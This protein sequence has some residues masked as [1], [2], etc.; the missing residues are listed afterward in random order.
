MEHETT[1]SIKALSH[2]HLVSTK[3]LDQEI[4]GSC[5]QFG[6]FGRFF[7]CLLC[8]VRGNWWCIINLDA[9]SLLV[10]AVVEG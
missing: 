10:F 2:V 1:W 9:A 5:T 4:Y 3:V 8:I 7:A 6:S